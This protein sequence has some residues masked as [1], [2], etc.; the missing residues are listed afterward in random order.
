MDTAIVA[1]SHGIHQPAVHLTDLEGYAGNALGFIRFGYFYQLQTANRCI[2]ERQRL[3]LAGLNLHTLWGTIENVAIHRLGFFGGDYSAGG[4][5]RESNAAI[6]VRLIDSLIRSNGCATAVCDQ[7][8]SAS[9]RLLCCA[10]NEFLD[11]EHLLGRVVEFDGLGVIGVD[12]HGLA[13]LI[14]INHIAVD[15]LGFC[16]NDGA[17]NTGNGDFS[18]PVCGV[19]ALG[20]NGSVLQIDVAAV[21][22][23]QLEFYA[24]QR[25]IRLG[26]QLLDDQI[27][28]LFVLK[29]Q[30]LYLA[31]LDLD[32]LR[33]GIKDI[34][35]QRFC[36]LSG[37]G[38]TRLQIGD[39]YPSI[40]IGDEMPVIRSHGSAGVVRD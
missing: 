22:V 23:G 5:V 19:Q 17:N 8:F 7:K 24:G 33:R 3:Y 20:G 31:G 14:F 32:G 12:R 18:V 13:A 29:G 16:D 4:Q 6:L 30:G 36:F 15:C 2:V 35:I 9:Q 37:D 10:G 34:T 25:L 27:A 39:G 38:G 21:S 1:G 28:S 11:D 40:L 26:V